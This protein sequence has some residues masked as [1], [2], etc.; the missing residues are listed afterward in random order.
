M[1]YCST[2]YFAIDWQRCDSPH[3]HVRGVPVGVDANIGGL[4]FVFAFW[5]H[6]SNLRLCR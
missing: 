5:A 6:I 2:S 4:L 3:G 1:E